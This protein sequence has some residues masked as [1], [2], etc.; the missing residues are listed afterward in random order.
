MKETSNTLNFWK[1]MLIRY[2]YIELLLFFLGASLAYNH[3]QGSSEKWHKELGS[4]L[5]WWLQTYQRWS[6]EPLSSKGTA[7]SVLG[8]TDTFVGPSSGKVSRI[9]RGGEQGTSPRGQFR[10]GSRIAAHKEPT[11]SPLSVC[12]VPAMAAD[13]PV[14]GGKHSAPLPC[15]LVLGNLS[16]LSPLLPTQI[17][18]YTLMETVLLSAI[19]QTP[20]CS[21]ELHFPLFTHIQATAATSLH[22]GG[23]CRRE[24]VERRKGHH[25][26]SDLG[27]QHS[28]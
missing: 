14:W 25:F 12:R 6:P 9:T 1:C 17:P 24:L 11:L 5:L 8:C 23:L 3:L 7:L 19:L 27:S 22:T 4:C 20:P 21:K 13:A 15:S 2:S 10:V 28:N 18:S 26:I 16:Q